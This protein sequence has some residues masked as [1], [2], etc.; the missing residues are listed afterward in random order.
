MDLDRFHRDTFWSL[1]AQGRLGLL[2]ITGTVSLLGCWLAAKGA[3]AFA[4]RGHRRAIRAGYL[5]LN[6]LILSIV[7]AVVWL[8][9]PQIYYEFYR[10]LMPGLPAQWVLQD[11]GRVAELATSVRLAE[12]STLAMLLTGGTVLDAGGFDGHGPCERR[13]EESVE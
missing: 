11:V 2:L 6:L 5:V 12:G 10:L 4:G 8:L 1:S 7:Y 3:G 13:V 9:V